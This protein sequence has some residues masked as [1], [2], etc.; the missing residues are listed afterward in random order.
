MRAG[1]LPT[2]E[3]APVGRKPIR[4]TRRGLICGPA[5][6]RNQRG[7]VD[8]GA[9]RVV[10]EP[11][12]AGFE[13]GHDRVTCVREVLRGMLPR[14]A[15]AAADVT[16][17][18]TSAQVYPPTAAAFAFDASMSR[19]ASAGGWVGGRHCAPSPRTG[20]PLRIDSRLKALMVM[21]IHSTAAI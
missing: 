8:N 14:G 12:F 3:L 18:D 21:A 6:R 13:A 7:P 9:A 15:I 20:Y 11:I 2:D 5:E 10:P 1:A 16:A 4:R 19:R 17:S